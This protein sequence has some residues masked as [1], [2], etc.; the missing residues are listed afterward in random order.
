MM[1][2][3]LCAL[4]LALLLLLGGCTPAAQEEMVNPIRF[5]FCAA[6]EEDGYYESTTGALAPETVDLGRRDI[7]IDDVLERYFAAAAQAAD[8]SPFPEGL[9][10]QS[11][12]LDGGVLTVWFNDA[13]S[14]LSGVQLTLCAAALT[15]TLTQ[16]GGVDGVAIRCEGAILSEDWQEV[17]TPEDFLFMDTSSEHPEYAVQ[18]YFLDGGRL[19]AQRRMIACSEKAQLPEL[20]MNALLAGPGAGSLKRAIPSGTA[21]LDLSM[22][23]KTCTVVLSDEFALCDTDRQTAEQAV[24]AVVLTLCSLDAVESVR[25]QL[26]SGTELQNCRID[27]ALSPAADWLQRSS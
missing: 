26:L 14:A 21:L 5:Y 25:V 13:F 10:A 9:H 19:S 8:R 18:L 22:D 7:S 27:E 4:L 12:S 3:R 6:A 11:L 17:F 24:H 23:G 16:I 15:L 2:I 20:T 1:K